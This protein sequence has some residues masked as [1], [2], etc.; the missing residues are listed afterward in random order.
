MALY[1]NSRG[2]YMMFAELDV[3]TLMQHNIIDWTVDSCGIRWQ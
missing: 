3:H 2:F 1:L